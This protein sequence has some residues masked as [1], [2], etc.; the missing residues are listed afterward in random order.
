M[1]LMCYSR[2]LLSTTLAMLTSLGLHQANGNHVL[3]KNEQTGSQKAWISSQ[4]PT[5]YYIIK[6]RK[7]DKIQGIQLLK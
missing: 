5:A 7:T 4:L 1:A 2:L 3:K 6:I